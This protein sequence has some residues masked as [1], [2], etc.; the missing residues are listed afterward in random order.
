[1]KF[2]KRAIRSGNG[3]KHFKHFPYGCR[4]QIEEHRIRIY[5][6]D[7]YKFRN[8]YDGIISLVWEGTPT[9]GLWAMDPTH[10]WQWELEKI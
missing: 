9:A 1:M 6:P 4:I 2:P 5:P 10:R 7:G 3:F 8:G